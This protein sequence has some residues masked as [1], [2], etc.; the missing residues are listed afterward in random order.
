MNNPP[1]TLRTEATKVALRKADEAV[2]AWATLDFN[3]ARERR[4]LQKIVASI[5]RARKQFDSKLFLVVIFGPLKAGKSTLTNCLAGEHVSLT[6]FGKET[7]L[8]PSM[9]VQ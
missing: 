2:N 8:R 7:T 4:V 5:R 6:G 9:I 1:E 3:P